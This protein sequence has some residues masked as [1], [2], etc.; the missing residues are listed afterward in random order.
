MIRINK[1]LLIILIIGLL[2]I[3]LTI[4]LSSP[5]EQY[6]EEPLPI[7]NLGSS[8]EEIDV[9]TI[10]IQEEERDLLF[11]KPKVHIA[12]VQEMID[13]LGWSL[14]KEEYKNSRL[15]TWSD[16]KNTFKYNENNDTLL[17]TI[18]KRIQ[19]EEGLEGFSQIFNEYLGINYEFRF[20][21]EEESG[22]G[23]TRYYASRMIGD[24]PLQFGGYFGYSD[25][26][27]FDKN[28]NLVGGELLLV[29]VEEGEGKIPLIKKEDL[30][31][32]VNQSGYPK[33]S[34]VETTVLYS[35]IDL[36][37]LDDAWEDIEDSVS[38]C[39]A[40][41]YEEIF[42]FKDSSQGY[43]FPVFKISSNCDV[44]YKN[45]TYS[46]PATFYLNAVDPMYITNTN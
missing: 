36:S 4:F 9:S 7:K 24:F 10:N 17:F 44:E 8:E 19:I 3:L 20:E 29:E 16:G 2:F 5:K 45:Q 28:G 35:T 42:L 25:Y 26:L 40:S 13:S 43:L 38:N 30:I 31:R 37:Y 23:I 18:S 32:Y 14:K 34:Y 21:R 39:K 22:T 6:P 33:E 15:V 12:L 41:S 11:V 1:K 46:V 27:A